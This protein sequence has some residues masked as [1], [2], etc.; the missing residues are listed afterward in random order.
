MKWGG[1]WLSRCKT[2]HAAHT[3]HQCVN[4]VLSVLLDE[5]VDITE[6]ATVPV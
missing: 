1:Q 5:V 3:I 4:D 2:E 6:N